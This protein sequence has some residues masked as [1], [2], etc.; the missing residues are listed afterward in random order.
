MRRRG[1]SGTSVLIGQT[2]PDLVNL[3]VLASCFV[4]TRHN[5]N[6]LKQENKIKL[7]LV[8]VLTFTLASSPFHGE[9]RASMLVLAEMRASLVKTRLKDW[10]FS[11]YVILLSVQL[12]HSHVC[13]LLELGSFSNDNGEGNENVTILYIQ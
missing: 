9:M 3:H 12:Q 7:I 1:K 2:R 10:F 11:V 13:S 8:L 5:T 4:F 6:V